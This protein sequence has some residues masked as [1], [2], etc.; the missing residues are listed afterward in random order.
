MDNPGRIYVMREKHFGIGIR[1]DSVFYALDVSLALPFVTI[2]V[3][4]GKLKALE[5]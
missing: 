4:L 3:G 5:G 2:V 1:W